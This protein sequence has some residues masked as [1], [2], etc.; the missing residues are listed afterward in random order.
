MLTQ[1]TSAIP[2]PSVAI[3]HVGLPFREA[4]AWCSAEGA[5][6]MQ[7]SATM[8]ETRVRTMDRS[9]RRGIGDAVRA[10]GALT[11]GIDCILPPEHLADPA[12][13]DTAAQA[14]F[15]AIEW[16]EL[17][18]RLTVTT[19]LPTG[20]GH[21]TAL[22]VRTAVIAEAQRRG[23]TLAVLG[24]GHDADGPAAIAIDPPVLLAAGESVD[25]ACARAGS[26][27]AGLRLVD[28]L[29]SGHRGPVLQPGDARL[30]ALALAAT[31]ATIG[32][33]AHPVID[34]RGWSD[35]RG[36]VVGTLDRWLDRPAPPRSAAHA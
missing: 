24:G 5:R 18:G 4:L 7:L 19:W 21:A 36:G 27:L 31:L 32:F 6:A 33:R 17:L 13:A 22:A 9:E 11:A 30:D 35:P 12:R 34:T 25:A 14:L 26:R 15:A 2:E 3:E 16:A 10:S 1:L 8:P 28:L 20:D 29:R 23:V